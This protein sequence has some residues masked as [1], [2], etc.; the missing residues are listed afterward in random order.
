MGD[1]IHNQSED[2]QLYSI[3][4]FSE[5]E[6]G[7]IRQQIDLIS[8]QNRI[9]VT[10]EL[11]KI[12]RDV[13]NKRIKNREPFRPFAPSILEENISEL[14]LWAQTRTRRAS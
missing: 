8:E 5:E 11:F 14:R 2:D 10:D 3:E 1:I 9:P 12:I 4:G 13:L 7:E 6:Q